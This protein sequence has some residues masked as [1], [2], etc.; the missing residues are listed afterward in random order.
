MAPVVISLRMRLSLFYQKSPGIFAYF[1]PIV[2]AILDF[3]AGFST[4]LGTGGK[5]ST[6]LSLNRGIQVWG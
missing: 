1:F 2:R 4:N 3:L 5:K 6:K